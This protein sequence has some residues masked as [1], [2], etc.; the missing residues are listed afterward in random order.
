[1]DE[2]IDTIR[3]SLLSGAKEGEKKALDKCSGEQAVRKDDEQPN[4][5]GSNSDAPKNPYVLRK[6]EALA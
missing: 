5:D 6:L 2:K 3:E 4:S 1:M